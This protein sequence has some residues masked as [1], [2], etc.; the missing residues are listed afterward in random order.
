VSVNITAMRF[1][2]KIIAPR[3]RCD[4][5]LSTCNFM[6]LHESVVSHDQ[7]THLVGVMQTDYLM[8]LYRD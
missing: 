8:L 4:S 6:R 2:T 3:D 1:V 5:D 7:T